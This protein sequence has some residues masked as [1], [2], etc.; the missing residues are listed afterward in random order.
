MYNKYIKEKRPCV[1][2]LLCLYSPRCDPKRRR[3]LDEWLHRLFGNLHSQILFSQILA[4]RHR[5]VFEFHLEG[6]LKD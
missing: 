6:D 1:G 2:T 3:P 5:S 4:K